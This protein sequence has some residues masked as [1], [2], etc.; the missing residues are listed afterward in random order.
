[1]IR[2]EEFGSED[3]TV[4]QPTFNENLNLSLTEK[5]G[6]TEKGVKGQEEEWVG[7]SKEEKPLIVDSK[8]N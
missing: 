2:E 8:D 3:G 6:M 5:K 1:M 4:T 7:A